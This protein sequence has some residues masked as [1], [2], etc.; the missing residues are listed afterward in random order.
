[1]PVGS[2]EVNKI[3]F[4]AL[5]CVFLV[6]GIAGLILPGLPGTFPLI[7]SAGFFAKSDPRIERW[8]LEHP[9]IGPPIR[10]WRAE[11]S[12]SK[13]HKKL[14]ITMLWISIGLAC[15]FAPWWSAIIAVLCA[16]GVS[17]YILTRPTRMA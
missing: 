7:L 16:I 10:G 5:G 11:G 3:F 6:I 15:W 2:R 13:K 14:A 4:F 9:H 1:M 17:I 12:I 8:M